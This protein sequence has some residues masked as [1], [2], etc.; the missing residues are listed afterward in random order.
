MPLKTDDLITDLKEMLLAALEMGDYAKVQKF[1]GYL[2][3]L[4]DEKES[5]KPEKKPAAKRGPKP[6]MKKEKA[7]AKPAKVA[8]AKKPSKAKKTTTPRGAAKFPLGTKL[9]TS[10]KGNHY[11]VEVKDGG[12]EYE[13]ELFSALSRMIDKAFGKGKA[14]HLRNMANWRV[15]TK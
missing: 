12:Y 8:K 15:A 1:A 3:E 4:S 11:I 2:A 10:Y 6:K 5:H 13:G 7:A 9:M 14:M